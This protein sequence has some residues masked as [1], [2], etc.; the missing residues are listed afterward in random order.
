MVELLS[1]LLHF[2]VLLALTLVFFCPPYVP[3]LLRLVLGQQWMSTPAPLLLQAYCYLIPVL[4]INGITEAFVQAVASQQDLSRVS[5]WMALST[6]I[7]LAACYM[8][9]QHLGLKELGLII[10]NAI[11][12]SSRIM[13]ALQYIQ[14]WF[15]QHQVKRLSLSAIL[16]PRQILIV[17][18]LGG[19]VIRWSS[20]NIVNETS[21]VSLIRHFGVG[22][23]TGMVLLAAMFV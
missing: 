17:A 22:M 15:S 4:G 2:H 16:P 19:H 13:F 3:P 12:M 7:Y 6:A 1:T 11:G 5:R 21:S 8:L 20:H 9:C 14:N 18:G 23:F 10:A